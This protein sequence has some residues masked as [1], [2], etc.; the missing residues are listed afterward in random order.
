MPFQRPRT[1]GRNWFNSP[2]YD[3]YKQTIAAVFAY[4][5]G[6]PKLEE[7]LQLVARYY[8]KTKQRADLDNLIKAT[9]DG[10]QD[11]GLIVDDV[12]IHEITASKAVD[13]KNPRVEIELRTVPR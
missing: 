7:P 5:F 4:T 3:K 10:M 13:G 6:Q 2:R 12:W 1:N 11:G 9:L 8:R